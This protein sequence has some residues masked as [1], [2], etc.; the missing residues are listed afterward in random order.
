MDKELDAMIFA[1][2]EKANNAGKEMRNYVNNL[3]E[4]GIET[5]NFHKGQYQAYTEIYSM[6][7]NIKD[8]L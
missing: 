5:Y 2:N 4:Y 1:V 6:L 7:M 3:S 8:K